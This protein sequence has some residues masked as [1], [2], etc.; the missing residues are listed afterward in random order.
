MRMIWKLKEL[1]RDR[2]EYRDIVKKYKKEVDIINGIVIRFCD[3]IETTAKTINGEICLNDKLLNYNINK[4]MRY[5]IHELVHV[6]QHIKNE[7]KAQ[8]KEKEYL[9]NPDEIEAFEAQLDFMEDVDDDPSG[10]LE[11][12]LKFHKIKDEGDREDIISDLTKGLYDGDSIKEEI[13][14]DD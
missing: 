9:E 12:L 2:E 8:R 11:D 6:F 3:D 5:V 7:G 14:K 10:Y 4:I 1:C 13:L